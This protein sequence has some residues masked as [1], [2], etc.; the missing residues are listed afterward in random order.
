M[1]VFERAHTLAERGESVALL[2]VV[3]KD[4]S[5][6]REVGARMLV[7]DDDEY[8]T[9]GGGS[10]EG[11]A[12]DAGRA[13]LDGDEKPGVRTYELHPDGNTGMVC[14]GSMDVFVDRLR[15]RKRLAIAG[16][17]H[18]ATE[19]APLAER[20]GY[21]VTVIDDREEYAD[22]ERFPDATEAIHGDYG[23]ALADLALTDESAVAVATRSGTFDARAVGAALD[24]GAGYVGLVAS[25]TKADH[26]LDS[27]A[28]DGYAWSDLARVR[29]PIGL[30]LGGGNPADVA[31]S[32]LAEMS[33][34][35]HG[36]SGD[37]MATLALDDCVVVRGGGDLGSGVAYRLHRA[38]YPVVVTDV[39]QPT[40]VRRAVAF[41]TA[42]Y[43][44]EVSVESVVGR[45][46]GGIDDAIGVLRDGDVPV[47]ADPEGAVI[48]ELDPEGVVDAIMAKGKYDTG[49]RRADADVVI[50]LGP[51]FEAG[52]DV[53]AVVETDRGHELGRVFYEGTASAYDGEPGTRE[54]Y[55]HERVFY[56]PTAGVWEPTVEIGEC[57]VA[58]DRLGTVADDSVEAEIDGL[59]RGLVHSG[60]A[61][62]EGTKLGDVDPRGEAVDYRKISDKALCLGG[63]VLEALLQLE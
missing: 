18:I 32:V 40:V 15:G 33:R 55:T 13:V 39:E 17:G 10:V 25:A 63:G 45:H 30:D 41:G 1:S 12:I 2:T 6:P 31:L 34:D 9:I 26:V 53:D 24:A 20:L 37:R 38:G 47:L 59:V 3:G 36:A 50:G 49:T 27:L 8:G 61:V 16:G 7:T 5:A 22:G 11:L 52:T 46:V 62:E 43:E 21:D 56:A 51:G 42:I 54:G 19:L 44:G 29:A 48:D 58:G 4:G 28:D 35:R 57:V 14:G 23:A 60:V